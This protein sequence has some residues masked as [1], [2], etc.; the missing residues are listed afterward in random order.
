MGDA[1]TRFARAVAAGTKAAMPLR[2]IFWEDRDDQVT[3][4]F[5]YTWVIASPAKGTE[6]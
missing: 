3:V 2:A 1:D 4:P 6:A 5:G